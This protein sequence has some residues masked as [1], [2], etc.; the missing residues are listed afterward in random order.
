MT[1]ATALGAGAIVDACNKIRLGNA[2]VTVLEAQVGL[3]VV[4]DEKQKENFGPVDGELVLQKISGFA[5]RSWN[6][7]GHDPKQFRHYGPMA[8]EFY[9]AFGT[10]GVGT[11]SHTTTI[12]S[13][14][15]SGI[16]MVG[17]QALGK[18][19]TQPREENAPLKSVVAEL[20]ARLDALEHTVAGGTG[21]Q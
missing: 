12:N 7:I 2:S 4:S 8:Q 14:D 3:T 9:P 18:Q 5:P 1:N 17:V 20:K 6:Y 13:S 16:L 11:I 15:L 10:G 19:P 21:K